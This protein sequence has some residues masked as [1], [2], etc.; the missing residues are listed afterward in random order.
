MPGFIAVLVSWG[1]F[2]FVLW[3]KMLYRD[4]NGI[5]AG[6]INVWGDWAA[7]V[8]YASVFA[9][10][11]AADWFISHPLYKG[12][13]FTYPFVADAISGLLMRV[14]VDII[15]AFI[16]PSILCSLALL[17]VLYALYYTF[18]KSSRQAALAVTLNFMSGGLG[19]LWFFKD[20]AES[21]RWATIF[22]PPREY[23]HMP[24]FGVK[25]ITLIT[26]QLVPQR[27]FLLG[28]PIVL[29]LLLWLHRTVTN[30]KTIDDGVMMTIGLLSSLLLFVHVHAF[31]AFV[32][33]CAAYA[34]FYAKQW[35]SWFVL[36][37]SAGMSSALIFS[38]LYGGEIHEGFFSFMP[39]WLANKSSLDMN[40][41]YFWFLN[42]GIFLPFA[43]FA[44]WRTKF[45]KQPIF[46]AAVALFVACN[47][48]LFQPFDWDNSK[49]LCFVYLIL[50]M[51]VAK[52]CAQLWRTRKFV[53]RQYVVIGIVV[54]CLSGALDLSRMLH[55]NRVTNMLWSNEELKLAQDFRKISNPTDTILT[56][57]KHNLWA[58]NLTGRQMILGY[59]GW[60]WTYGIDYSQR[61][62]DIQ[63]MYAGDAYAEELFQ[64]YAVKFIV[65]GPTER[66][67]FQVNDT[68]LKS[69]GIVV[70]S[71]PHYLVIE[72][73]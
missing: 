67:D 22:F 28:L 8:S 31:I 39:W 23:T 69:R 24:Q 65:I 44:S 42:W 10:R 66:E 37:A 52:Y 9:Y 73:E 33:F 5:W 49:L 29:G 45:Y 30:K 18:L 59:R 61:E 27:A 71:S 63:H 38:A 35:K 41:I 7:H 2:F 46:T 14:G 3:P 15:P 68:Y 19:F 64:K 12:V 36:A 25:W 72:V 11:P 40:W 62:Q 58:S 54:M 60:I 6:W 20:L 56:S 50:C 16:V 13:K 1:T 34:V 57:D 51:P 55:T 43:L 21:P 17:C 48:V 70:L 26:S 4:A 47:V 32:F 53:I